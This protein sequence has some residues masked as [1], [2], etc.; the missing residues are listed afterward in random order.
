MRLNRNAVLSPYPPLVCPPE[1]DQGQLNLCSFVHPL[2]WRTA[3]FPP[4]TV[5]P[6]QSPG[7]L[8]A[9]RGP[10]T[11]KGKLRAWTGGRGPAFA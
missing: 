1:A 2:P 5:A 7:V 10:G 11:E 6:P 3:P 9:L 4:V 8:A